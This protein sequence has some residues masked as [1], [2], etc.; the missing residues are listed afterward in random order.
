MINLENKTN[1]DY[2]K[3]NTVEY[4]KEFYEDVKFENASLLIFFE[5]VYSALPSFETLL[6]VGGGPTI[7]QIMSAYKKAKK[8]IFSEYV[9]S[10]RDFVMETLQKDSLFNWDKYWK[11]IYMLRG[12]ELDDNKLKKSKDELN[13]KIK[14]IVPCDVFNEDAGVNNKAYEKFDVVSSNFVAE[15][16]SRNERE[17]TWIMEK[18]TS[19]IK[20]GGYLVMTALK[21]ARFYKVGNEKFLAYPLTDE[22]L[23]MY[24]PTLGYKDIHIVEIPSSEYGYDA[25]L[26][27]LAKYMPDTE[28]DGKGTQ[29]IKRNINKTKEL[30]ESININDSETEIYF[31]ISSRTT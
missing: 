5:M 4:I 31:K 10:N 1:L 7:Y 18:I 24:L 21:N 15:S 28:Q 27:V 13:A 25:M 29:K 20:K 9:K 23:V 12:E 2:D 8:I 30:I 17:Y 6:E 22:F 19:K 16:I 11:F 26:L 3:F 14:D